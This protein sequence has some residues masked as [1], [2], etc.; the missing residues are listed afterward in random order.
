[1]WMIPITL[2]ID[3]DEQVFYEGDSNKIGFLV[4][5]KISIAAVVSSRIRVT[6][7]Q[8]AYTHRPPT[9]AEVALVLWPNPLF[10]GQ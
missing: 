7:T 3:S 1:M 4:V 2:I 10:G 9:W 8:K 5:P 6:R